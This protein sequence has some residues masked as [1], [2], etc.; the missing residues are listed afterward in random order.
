[1]TTT[2]IEI[3]STF[4]NTEIYANDNLICKISTESALMMPLEGFNA[5]FG[6]VLALVVGEHML[7]HGR[8]MK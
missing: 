5:A 7:K 3:K 2:R 4:T 6:S 1:M 8:N